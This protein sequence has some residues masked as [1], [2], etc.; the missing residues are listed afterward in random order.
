MRPSWSCAPLA[1]IGVAQQDEVGDA[2]DGL[3]GWDRRRPFPLRSRVMRG[4][5]SVSAQ[6]SSRPQET[7]AARMRL[8]WGESSSF[9]GVS[10]CA[11][12]SSYPEHLGGVRVLGLAGDDYGAAGS[13]FVALPAEV[14]PL[15]AVSGHGDAAGLRLEHAGEREDVDPAVEVCSGIGGGVRGIAVDDGV[16]FV[17]GAFEQADGVD[18]LQ[19]GVGEPVAQ[20]GES[21]GQAAVD[22]ASVATPFLVSDTKKAS[23]LA[24]GVAVHDRP[25]DYDGKSQC[26]LGARTG[27]DRR[28]ALV[29][30]R[31]PRGY[32][33]CA[34]RGGRTRRCGRGWRA[35]VIDD[36][37][38][39]IVQDLYCGRAA[40]EEDESHAAERLDV[41][42]LR[43][44]RQQAAIQGAILVLLPMIAD[45]CP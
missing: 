43:I 35:P 27:S 42:A 39:E 24:F 12:R 32:A 15:G 2:G 11:R 33:G 17:G 25:L 29:P 3:V 16:V 5:S 26:A 22:F 18:V 19:G 38:V 36:A 1:G 20:A 40:R 28:G 10:R 7:A 31:T 14:I 21:A 30:N 23:I 4:S 45:A 8:A 41:G 34:W 44:I 6:P 9:T 13:A 37:G